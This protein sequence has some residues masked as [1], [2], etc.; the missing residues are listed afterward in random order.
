M[1]GTPREPADHSPTQR[2]DPNPYFPSCSNLL[3]FT[4]V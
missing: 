3:W 1:F 2:R 4:L